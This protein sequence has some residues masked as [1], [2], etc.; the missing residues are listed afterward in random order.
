MC[1]GCHGVPLLFVHSPCRGFLWTVQME[2]MVNDLQM[3]KE[4]E[5]QFEGE[6]LAHQRAAAK[7]CL[8][9]VE[10]AYNGPSPCETAHVQWHGHGL[11]S[12]CQATST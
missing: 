10:P 3:A 1:A 4:R 6:A 8:L 12:S 7:P 5:R 11:C 9:R 2:G